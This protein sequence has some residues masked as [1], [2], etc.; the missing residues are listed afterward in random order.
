MAKA[1]IAV[2]KYELSKAAYGGAPGKDYV[3][4]V[5][6]TEAMPEITGYSIILGVLFALIFAAANTYLGLKVGLTISA[7]IPGAILATGILKGLF[8]RNNILEAN[9]V[10]SLAAMGESIAGGIIFVLPA[11]ILL[12]FGLSITT[13]IIVTLIG[14]IMGVFFITPVRRYLIVEEHGILIYPESMAAAEVLVTGSEGGSGFKTV[15]LGMGV[16]GLYKIASGGFKFWG[17]NASYTITSYQG[18]LIGIDTVASLMGVGFIVGTKTS[19]LMFGGSVIAWLALIPM[20]KFF[21]AGLPEAVFPSAIPIAEMSASQVWSSYI[22]YIG[23]G[24]VATGGFISLAKSLPTIISSFKQAIA[25][26]GKGNAGETNRMNSEA[27]LTWVIG[28]AVGGFLLTWLVP[29]VGGGIVGS[30]LAVI[31]SFFFAVV[32]ARMVGM[33]GASN[34]PVSGMTIATLLIVTTVMKLMGNTGDE[35]IKTALMIGGVVC[36]A[37]AVAGGTAQSLKTTFIIGGTP[38]KVQVSMFVALA[39]AS[40]AAAGTVILMDSAY[41][42]GKEVVPA[43]QATLMKMIAEGIMTGQLPWILVFIGVA[44][45]GFCFLANIPILA[46][47]LGIYLPI[48]LNAAIFLGG[49]VRDLVERKMSIVPKIKDDTGGPKVSIEPVENIKKDKAVERG[50]LLASGLVAG[51]A[52]IGIVIGIFAVIGKDI[53]FGLQ[54]APALAASN[55]FAFFMFL[56]LAIWIYMY[57]IKKVDQI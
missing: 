20:I 57:S 52:L 3:P 54:I 16:G 26:M 50:I 49:I 5:P 46:V 1:E 42:I 44:L 28:A 4:Y 15:L 13:I 45:A 38:R 12:G 40:I 7:G 55:L 19:A 37:I 17:E 39:V 33:V 29:V 18:T 43:P 35:G 11:L 27:P 32:S 47:A 36:V 30:I 21:G 14:G 41:G 6:T 51:D 2:K 25:G 24:A 22:R 23:A 48:G 34:N 53:A 10:A 31:F 9:V 56:A 8:R